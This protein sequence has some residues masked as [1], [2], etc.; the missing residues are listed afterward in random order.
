MILPRRPKGTEAWSEE[1]LQSIITRDSMI[2]VTVLPE[3][4]L[5]ELIEKYDL[6]GVDYNWEYPGYRFGQGYL[7]D[8][9]VQAD[10]EG[11]SKL[12]F[13]TREI[14]T[15]RGWTNKVITLAYYPDGRQEQLLRDHG[16]GP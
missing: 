14:F 11:L 15:Q 13:A 8:S 3:S 12:L 1:E 16:G 2:G 6:D 5:V 10:Y 4:E 9:E 7:S